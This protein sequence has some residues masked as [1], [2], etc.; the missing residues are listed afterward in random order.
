MT[1]KK[2]SLK[3]LI[4]F[5]AE[6]LDTTGVLTSVRI[7]PEDKEWLKQQKEGMSYHIRKAIS[8]YRQTF[9]IADSND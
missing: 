3:N 8:L 5:Q 6:D 4:H 1:V 2:E 7:A 9:E